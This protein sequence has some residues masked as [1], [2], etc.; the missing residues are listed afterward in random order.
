M[1]G[2]L[3]LNSAE[4]NQTSPRDVVSQ[5]DNDT[6]REGTI[7]RRVSPWNSWH[8]VSE[9]L[10][11]IRSG[12]AR[13]RP[14][15]SDMTR[16]G[17]N[18]VSKHILAAQQL[19]LIEPDGTGRARG[20]RAAE[21]W[22]FR[23][24][25]G[26]VLVGILGIARMRVA[27]TTLDGTPVAESDFA[28]PVPEDAEAT[29]ERMAEEMSRLLLETNVDRP[30][31]IALGMPMPVDFVTGR[32]AD[33]VAPMGFHDRW[34]AAFDARSWFTNRFEL[35][36]WADA[37]ANLMALGAAAADDAPDNL[38]FVRVGTGL[39][40]GLVANGGVLRGES[41]VAGELNH[42]AVSTD[43][44]RIC[45]CGR[46]GC[47]ETV[48]SGWAMIADARAALS[49][50]RS[51]FLASAADE[52]EINLDVIAEGARLGDGACTEIVTRAGESLGRVLAAMVAWLNPAEIIVGGF[53]F[54]QSD[55]FRSAISRAVHLETLSASAAGLRISA[56]H[57]AQAEALAGGARL[58]TDSLLTPGNLAEWGPVGHPA[59]AR[60]LLDREAQ[61]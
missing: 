25:A 46:V 9:I 38:V 50:G 32:S 56:G 47:L 5:R 51:R 31:G 11:L 16:L 15:F 41:W 36:V 59:E 37:V 43:P 40:S 53:K 14:E 4:G 48:A 27:L 10:R 18:V 35:P 21:V 57:P 49:E 33:P 42:I 60:S 12:D 52:A 26:H 8:Q 20:G 39:G 6:L 23:S 19:Q 17:R 2:S 45:L 1:N 22:R 3:R 30:W 24:E 54:A 13:T 44:S 7:V 28:W 55:L 29:C 58:V 34:P 61:A